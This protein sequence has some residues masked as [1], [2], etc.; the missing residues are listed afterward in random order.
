M[1]P[2]IGAALSDEVMFELL[3]GVDCGVVTVL[4]FAT[5]NGEVLY[6]RMSESFIVNVSKVLTTVLASCG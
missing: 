4:E 2:V 1:P 3:F 6:G 5:N